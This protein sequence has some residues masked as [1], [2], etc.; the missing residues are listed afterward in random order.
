MKAFLIIDIS[1]FSR[2]SVFLIEFLKIQIMNHLF[3]KKRKSIL[4][5][6]LIVFS[7]Q[8]TYGQEKSVHGFVFDKSNHQAIAGAQVQV[9]KTEVTINT[10]ES[11]EYQIGIPRKHHNLLISKEGYHSTKTVLK[12]GFQ[13]KTINVFLAPVSAADSNYLKLKHAISLSVL[14][15]FNGALALRYEYF[16]K[17]KHSI[18]VHASF[19]V[20][21]RNPTTL[22]SES[23]TYPKYQGIKASP[24]YRFYP[25]R[26]TGFGFFVEGKLQTGYIYFSKLGYYFSRYEEYVTESFWS[27]G[28]GF[29]AGISFKMSKK[30]VGNLSIGYQYFPVNVPETSQS[31]SPGGNTITSTVNTD[32]WYRGGPGTHVDVKLTFGLGWH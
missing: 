6:C 30:G 5:I 18:G 26:K 7:F 14:E 11:G 32:W 20:F 15:V 24:F 2:Q 27:L 12:P 19:Y 21:G 13:H 16:L 25:V 31:T 28:F 22:G 9:D 1:Y 23:D 3:L 29:S 17:Q 10:D 4:M 8:L